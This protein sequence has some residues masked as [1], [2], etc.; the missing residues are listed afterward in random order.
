MAS[1]SLKMTELLNNI[2]TPVTEKTTESNKYLQYLNPV[3]ETKKD[4]SDVLDQLMTMIDISK[5]RSCERR[6]RLLMS[7]IVLASD[8]SFKGQV[9]NRRQKVQDLLAD[10]V[11]E[12]SENKSAKKF[13][14]DK[15]PKS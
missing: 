10:K 3:I 13:K 14:E 1:K 7:N 5:E 2:K 9:E 12:L 6:K 8:P 4:V 15:T 11:K